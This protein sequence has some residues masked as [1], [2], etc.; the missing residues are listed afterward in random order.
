MGPQ[1]TNS[2]YNSATAQFFIS[3]DDEEKRKDL[4][5]SYSLIREGDSN[6]VSEKE[7]SK[8]NSSSIFYQYHSNGL[9]KLSGK[10]YFTLQKKVKLRRLH[11]V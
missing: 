2:S 4:Y 8:S 7:I 9:N 11:L 3:S 5:S 6:T 10:D 1:F